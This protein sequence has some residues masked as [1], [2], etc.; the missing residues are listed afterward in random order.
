MLAKFKILSVA[1]NR[2]L[3]ADH[4]R[5][6]EMAEARARFLEQQANPGLRL[7]VPLKSDIEAWVEKC[8]SREY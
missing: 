3:T 4:D 6:K 1:C 8:F 5:S 2:R 7:D